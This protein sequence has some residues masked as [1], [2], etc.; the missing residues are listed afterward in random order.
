[1]NEDNSKHLRDSIIQVMTEQ[2]DRNIRRFMVNNIEEHP[3]DIARLA[4]RRFKISRV[5]VGRYLR[6]L[7]EGGILTAQGVTKDRVYALA[8]LYEDQWT[9]PITSETNED[10]VWRERVGPVLKKLPENVLTICNWGFTEMLN[11]VIDHSES[12]VA[13]LSVSMTA[14]AVTL[15]VHDDGIGIFNKI[16]QKFGYD[17]PRQ[18]LL[19]LSKGKLTTD[20]ANHTGYGIFF[21]SRAFDKFVLGSGPLMLL[22]RND[23]DEWFIEVQDQPE[24]SKGTY[25][26]MQISLMS[27]RKLT[28]IFDLYTNNVD[29]GFTKTHVPLVL[30]K[31]EGEQLVS[32]S[33]ARR[34]LARVK[35]FK[36]V[37]LDFSGIKVIGQAFADEIFRVF[38]NNNPGIRIV[39]VHTDK[40]V[41]KM[42][43]L[44][45]VARNRESAA[46]K[47]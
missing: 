44:A 13:S 41:E 46:N 40:D 29:G 38:A 28:E 26:K 43:K 12:P 27:D 25:V 10:S 3:R 19:E 33:Q 30:A 8:T 20:A 14:R 5:A 21:T 6:E 36:E 24:A 16:Q 17:D 11:N 2:N 18:A 35:E 7:V 42:I 32:R 39:Y 4:A 31:Y 47:S 22:R 37:F 45:K 1:M 15:I 34:V 9:I 23:N